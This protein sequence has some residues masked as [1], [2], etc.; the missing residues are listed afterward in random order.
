MLLD[1]YQLCEMPSPKKPDIGRKRRQTTQST[2][3]KI[4]PV[5]LPLCFSYDATV[6]YE[7]MVF[8]GDPNERCVHCSALL[9][10]DETKGFCCLNGKVRLDGLPVP[11][12][13]LLNLLERND[14]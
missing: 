12:Q 9:W 11:P 13:P 7:K 5:V 2:S 4:L 14:P 3:R 10:K 1:A 8:I 6:N